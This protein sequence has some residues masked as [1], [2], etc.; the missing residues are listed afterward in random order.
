MARA[1]NLGFPRL[2]A[3]REWKKACEKYWTGKISREK[4]HAQAKELM[5][6]H[7]QI[8]KEAGMDVIPT[9]DF[10]YYDQMLDTAAMVGAVPERYNHRSNEN[11]DLNTY[12]TM[13]RGRQDETMDVTAMQMTKW[14]D[15]NYHYIVPEFDGQTKF[16]LASDHIFRMT[17]LAQRSNLENPRPVL[18]GPATFLL[19][20]KVVDSSINRLDLIPGLVEVYLKVLKRLKSAGIAWVQIDEP[21]LVL[22]LDDEAQAIF[23]KVYGSLLDTPDRPKI[24]M[25]T[26]FGGLEDNCGFAL[27]LGTEGLHV[28]LV[29]DSSQLIPLLQKVRPDMVLSLGVVDGRNVWR[30]DLARAY[31]LLKTAADHIGT[32]QIEVAPSC[33]LL[34][35]PIDLDQETEINPEIR[36][37]LAFGVQKLREVA[38]LTKALNE[39]RGTVEDEF[40]RSR[41]ALRRRRLS[42]QAHIPEV[43][44]RSRNINN[45]M[46]R[47]SAPFE[48]RRDSQQAH[49][50]LPLLPTTTIG[51][52]PQTRE[53]RRLRLDLKQ[54]NISDL[55]YINSLEK[56][57]TDAI[58]FQEETG[59][60][61]LVHGEFERN[62]MVQYFAEQMDGYLVTS[63]GWVQ[64]FGTRA[65]KPPIIYGDV[66]RRMPMTVDWT[67]YAQGLTDKPIKGMLTGPVTMLKWSFARD[68]LSRRE[69]CQQIALALRDEVED[70][71]TG[72]INIIQI[73]EPALAEGMP[74][75]HDGRRTY[76][77]WAVNAFRLTSAGVKDETQIHTHMCYSDFNEIID[78]IAQMDAD[79]ISIEASRSQMGLLD[80]FEAFRYPND[81]GPGIWDIHSPRIPSTEEME[82][83]LE[84]AVEYID[85]Q[86]LWVNPDCGLKTRRWEEIRPALINM[87]EA[88]QQMREI[89]AESVRVA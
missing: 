58:R 65:V 87:V 71:E 74:L 43:Q 16:H 2:G 33:S 81:I 15:T 24:M 23:S 17:D 50:N 64:S 4:L 38:I 25:A 59:L 69:T 31:H 70:L 68:D 89:S 6:R 1:S 12:L 49:L 55:E 66:R 5:M 26:Y 56:A 77:D 78:A 47:R 82:A 21:A 60:D 10:A 72:G 62:D 61:V 8:Q 53:I 44:E 88:A 45:E 63:N 76:L 14:F 9:G 32:E 18:I 34:H 20:G 75:R 80:V 41:E 85:R 57:T 42:P 54:G 19:L 29:R 28:D 13:A 39:G 40:T 83:L 73:D 27:S 52:L 3:Q 35:V 67:R 79:V 36:E 48:A 7:W 22:D 86:R 37:W 30:T 51:S 46:M 11:V 84:R